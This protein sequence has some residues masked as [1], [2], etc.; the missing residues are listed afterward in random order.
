MDNEQTTPT[1]EAT[2]TEQEQTTPQ[3]TQQTTEGTQNSGG[4]TQPSFDEMLKNGGHQAEFDRRV[5]KAIATAK[6]NWEKAQ[7]DEQN[8]AAK[9]AKMT[10]K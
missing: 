9:L 1:N 4:S 7:A 10:A 3:G 6:A 5:T 2:Q 8:E